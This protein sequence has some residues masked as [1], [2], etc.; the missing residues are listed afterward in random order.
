V[1]NNV[2]GS[3]LVNLGLETGRLKSDTRKA[4][5]HFKDFDRKANGSLNR[6]K[7]GAGGL[8]TKLGSLTGV[9]GVLSVS[10]LGIMISRSIDASDEIQKLN[11]R[12]GASTEALSEYR[13]VME[14]SGVE[15][16][17]FTKGLQNMTDKISDAAMGT[18]EAA[19]SLRQLNLNAAELNRLAPEDQFE[20]IADALAEVEI[21][22]DKT[23]IAMDL[24][25]GRGV[26]LLQAMND[27]AAGI[28]ALRDEAKQLG[29]SLSVEQAN[30]AAD[31]KDAMTRFGGAVDGLVIQLTDKFI[32]VLTRTIKLLSFGIPAA[33]EFA[34]PAFDGIGKDIF[35]LWEAL[36]P[37]GITGTT[38]LE[39]ALRTQSILS[40]QLSRAQRFGSF[41]QVRNLRA[42]MDAQELL[43]DAIK[44][45][46]TIEKANRALV[47]DVTQGQQQPSPPSIGPPVDDEKAK[48]DGVLQGKLDAL[49]VSLL[50][51]E[52]RLFNSYANR[53]L[54]VE[55]AFESGLISEQRHQE[56]LLQ[57]TADF[58]DSRTAIVKKGY[59][60]RQKFADL[61]TMKQTKQVIGH[62]IELTRGVTGESR[63]LFEINK[64][65]GIANAIVNTHQGVTKTLATYPWYIAA[66]LAALH[67]ASGLAQVS[68]IK[69]TSF[70]GGSA[71]GSI[72]G[73]GVP[74][75]AP[76]DAATPISDRGRVQEV[77]ITID[78]TG[79]L[80]REQTDE[81]AR[82]LREYIADG[83]EGLA[84]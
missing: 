32:P 75:A 44:R 56:L 67:L 27:G 63:K 34:Q 23:R 8:I 4:S 48:S 54:I 22:G 74:P 47:V 60:D 41:E 24:F 65:A 39:E 40:R 82:S 31:A 55:D 58:E 66:P 53:Q 15:F 3:L 68:A 50:S 52:E 6:I 73:G 7:A 36:N 30:A 18:G 2:V 59:T 77:N 64:A 46:K 10:G 37:S 45:R 26:Q 80:S 17:S 61:S 9:M 69:S 78:G 81:I 21:Q 38:T 57:L 84:A 29:L 51:E 71:G 62:A 14:I 79:V 76:S 11:L 83:G 43:I 19:I 33:V 12:L 49:T 16:K 20:T 13:H 25:G 1:A 28:R 72:A 35:N 5:A 42:E 70:S